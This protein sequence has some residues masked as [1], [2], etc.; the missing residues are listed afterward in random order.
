VPEDYEVRP[1]DCIASLAYVRGLFWETVWEHPRNAGLKA[2]RLD[3]NILKP[4]DIVHLPDRE[5]KTVEKPTDQLH[6]FRRKGVPAKLRLR[7][8]Q[9]ELPEAPPQNPIESGTGRHF[10]AEDPDTS[11]T[12][13][14][15]EPRANVPY[16]LDID[17]RL[18][19]GQTDGEGMV[20][21]PIPPNARRGRLILEP[22]TL[23]EMAIDLNLGRLDPVT[24]IGG[25]KQR[26]ANLGFDC[27]S[28]NDEAT[29][30]FEAA[31]RA[32]QESRGLDVTGE[33]DQ[34]TRDKLEQEHGS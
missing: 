31:L 23:R 5:T 33:P 20:D 26:L 3:P 12:S 34:A 25:Q 22:G 6:H 17:G 32:Y 4:G 28:D 2:E 9:D 11:E 19:N 1:G 16:V 18:T 10:S 29:P 24:G 15:Q 27:G 8:M 13:E 30:E 7:I 14:R 21:L